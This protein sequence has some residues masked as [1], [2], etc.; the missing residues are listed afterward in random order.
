MADRKTIT[1]VLLFG[2]LLVLVVVFLVTSDRERI[3]KMT[4]ASAPGTAAETLAAERPMKKVTLFFPRDDD[5]LLV[6]EARDIPA[7]ASTEREAE[8]VLAE[9]IKGP[10]GDLAAALPPETTVEGLFIARD[11]TAYVDFSPDFAD[12]HPSGTEA[13]TSTVFSVVNTLAFNFRNIRKVFF[14]IDGR[15]RETL[16]GHLS[17]ERPILPDYSR[18]VKR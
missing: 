12:K 18:N 16:A 15:E 1:A 6:A 14:L 7:D 9:L 2:V 3:R 5:G 8:S 17:L 13:E 11:G 4:A 10:T